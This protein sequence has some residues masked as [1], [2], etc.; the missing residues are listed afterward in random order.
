MQKTCCYSVLVLLFVMPG[1]GVSCLNINHNVCQGM[2]SLG[3]VD[4]KAE[5]TAVKLLVLY[6]RFK[7]KTNPCAFSVHCHIA[8]K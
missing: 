4:S 5:T 1:N 7:T 2:S 8:S 6:V 3:F